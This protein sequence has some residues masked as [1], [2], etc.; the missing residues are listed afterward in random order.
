MLN[1]LSQKHCYFVRIYYFHHKAGNNNINYCVQGG[2]F[3]DSNFRVLRPVHG[4][5]HFGQQN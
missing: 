2:W 4:E 3:C 1:I 5:I